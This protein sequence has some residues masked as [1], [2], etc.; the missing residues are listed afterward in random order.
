MF[1]YFP[2]PATAL[3]SYGY[4]PISAMLAGP[5]PFLSLIDVPDMMIRIL[6]V[7]HDTIRAGV[8]SFGFHHVAGPAERHD[9]ILSH[10]VD[11]K[12]HIFRA[13]IFS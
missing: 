7:Q 8:L 3:L 6:P 12:P 5:A 2:D 13:V 11:V 1:G 4:D 9:L 10:F